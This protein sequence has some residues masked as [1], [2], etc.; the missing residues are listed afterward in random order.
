M[1]ASLQNS[2][3]I[4]KFTEFAAKLG[5]Q[6]HLSSLRDAFATIM[7]LYIL[8]GLA[9]LFNNT[10][11]QW[12]LSG[13]ALVSAQYWGNL[14]VNA[15]LNI[16]S[17]LVAAVIGYCLSR[18][19]G[20]ENPIAAALVSLATLIIMMPGSVT[21][22]P[23]GASDGV[24]VS[25]VL[26]FS[27]TGTQAMFAGI[28]IG[29]AATEL[30]IFVTGIK[31]LQINMGDSIP[32]AVGNSFSV[33]IPF[34][35]VM[36][37]F[38]IISAILNNVFHTDLITIITVMIQEPLRGV[39]TGLLGCV[40]LYS[41]GNFLWLFGIHQTVIYG[42]LLEPLLIVNMTQAMAA[43]AAGEPIPNIINVAFVPAFG[44]MG[45]SGSTIALIIA[46]LLFG[47][48]KATR[49]ICKMSAAP[50]CFNINEPVIFG[51]SIVY[52]ITMIIP[53]VLLPA[54]GIII[55]YAAT[56]LNFMNEC[57]VYIPWTTPPL[58][59]GYLATG[60]DFRAVLVQIVIIV[61]G[62]LLYLPFVK[63][64]DRVLSKTVSND[65]E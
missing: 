34:I 43:Y 1:G 56:A 31:K 27:N 51:Y 48:N 44:M 40:I 55:G 53:F 42:S 54:I 3:F 11:F 47:R 52:N 41:L 32:P 14:L 49:A 7:P 19:R 36:S 33:L 28:L 18:N 39:T 59:S 64:N 37:F 22:I 24:S 15:T 25:G 12:I 57:V 20:Y 58:L 45:G 62:V 2:K 23:D 63:I 5:S 6:V 61:I 38:A 10:V 9:V 29:L 16:S 50:G 17:L 8:A 46:T 13:P 60:G 30:F 4:D 21:V 35:L 65:S 26:A